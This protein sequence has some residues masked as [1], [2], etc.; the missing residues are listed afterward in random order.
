MA[1]NR[2]NTLSDT[3]ISLEPLGISQITRQ[4]ESIFKISTEEALSLAKVTKGYAFAFQALGMLIW[5][6]EDK[7]DI[8]SVLKD[9]DIL[10]DEYVYQ[11]IWSDLSD[12]EREIILNVPSDTS[13]KTGD[14]CEKSGITTQI[15]SKYRERLIN[16]GV[17]RTSGHGYVELAL[18]RLGE[19]FKFY[20]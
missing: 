20:I 6:K 18:P 8:A 3:K 11:K 17:L 14:L 9:L 2:Q 12:K 10:L 4:Y 5:E 19:I 13:I 7:S 16:K 1:K 15:F